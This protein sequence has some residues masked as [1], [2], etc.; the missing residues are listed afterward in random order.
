MKDP[1]H[2]ADQMTSA[3]RPMMERTELCMFVAHALPALIA[4]HFDFGEG[5]IEA[6]VVAAEAVTIGEA[7]CADLARRELERLG[8]GA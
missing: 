8:G 3:M 2:F 5:T 1:T 7:V 6:E 4:E